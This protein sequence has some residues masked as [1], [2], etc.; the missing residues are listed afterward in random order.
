MSWIAVG[1][2]V[3]G[4]ATSILGASKSAPQAPA[5]I[6]YTP[7]NLQQNQ[8]QAI[9]GN[10]N[11]LPQIQ[12]LLSSSNQFQG[13]QQSSLLNQ[14]LPGYSQFASNLLGTE[15]GLAAN[16]Y[17]LPA[18]VSSQLEQQAAEQNIG[19]GTGA[20]SGF[21]GSNMLRSLGVNELQY[22]QQNLASAT[23]A[24]QTLVGT[25]PQVSAMSPLSFLVSPQQQAGNQLTTNT[26]NQAIGQAGA[27]AS[28]AAANAGSATLWDS[29]TGTANSSVSPVLQALLGGST[30]STNGVSNAALNS[31]GLTPALYNYALGGGGSAAALG[32]P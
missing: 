10:Q 32:G 18:G 29:I 21:S 11:S 25:S 15:S 2:L 28:T 24:L 31:S 7:V 23:S 30:G 13:Q 16:P 6:P 27:N 19:A 5:S 26:N 4:G 17:Q 14:A 1:G 20:S 8:Q 9:A 12:S 3:V 22:G